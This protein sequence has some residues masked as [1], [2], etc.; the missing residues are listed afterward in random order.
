MHLI[1]VCLKNFQKY[2]LDNIRQLNYL[3]T[4]RIHVITNQN[5]FVHFADF[6]FINLIDPGT[7]TD[8]YNYWEKTALNK[9]FRNGFWALASQ[10]L[11]LLYAYI[12]KND[13]QDCVHIEN[14]VLLYYNIE[15]L[16]DVLDRDYI[17]VPF[18]SYN[19]SIMSI[20]FIPNARIFKI[21]LDH[22]RFDKN[23]MENFSYIKKETGI[24]QHFPI[25]P[26]HHAKTEEEKFVSANPMPFLFD[27]AAM[28]QYLGGIDPQNNPNDTV[29]FI[30]ETCVIKYNQFKFLWRDEK[31]FLCIGSE[32][33]PIFNLHIHNKTL[34]HFASFKNKHDIV[35]MLGPNEYRDIEM[36]ID[37]IY[38]HVSCFRYIYIITNANFILQKKHMKD[39]VIFIDEDI[40]PFKMKDV[41]EYFKQ[42]N[43]KSNRN[44]WYFQQLLKLYGGFV[45]K[46]IM[47][48]YLILDAD[49]FFLKPIRFMTDSG[50]FI[51][52]LGKEYHKPYFYHMNR[53]HPSLKKSHPHSGIVHHM[54][55][56]KRLVSE[57]FS[58]VESLHKKP[59]W[60]VFIESVNE[61]K[62]HNINVSE[63]GASEYEIYFNFMIVNHPE[64][65]ETRFLKW[66]NIPKNYPLQTLSS[67][68]FVSACHYL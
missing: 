49:V 10:R 66:A 41:A 50:K 46:D 56:N 65:V 16:I 37:Y 7:L 14:D 1:L 26:L 43:G 24:I 21:A 51:F 17:Y 9:N 23:D 54:M 32:M 38:K 48:N 58:L 11:F 52:S 62:N 19:R 30:N 36:Q 45:I 64:L 34:T 57:L 33:F 12:K 35:V 67:F 47:E 27:G 59:F 15:S 6:P 20:M 13:L 22:Y 39:N 2:I 31:P 29:G 63:S 61:H 42:Y 55:M 8:E 5:L 28:G 40:F 4:K 18:D 60:Q 3:K 25:F 53:L 68:D 44:G